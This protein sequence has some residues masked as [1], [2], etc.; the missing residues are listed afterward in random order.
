VRDKSFSFLVYE[1]YVLTAAGK[2]VISGNIRIRGPR[3]GAP[4]WPVT[5]RLPG[6]KPRKDI[7]V[8][9]SAAVKAAWAK[10]IVQPRETI[11]LAPA[12]AALIS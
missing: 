2:K 11:L 10:R 8:V 9:G 12:F 6:R 7:T 1:I 3:A 4:T 5:F